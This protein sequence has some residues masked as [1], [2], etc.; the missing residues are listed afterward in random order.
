MRQSR[1]WLLC[2]KDGV[3]N[4]FR[5]YEIM[6][7]VKERQMHGVGKGNIVVRVCSSWACLPWQPQLSKKREFIKLYL[8]MQLVLSQQQLNE[9][10]P[11]PT[12][13]ARRSCAH[14]SSDSHSSPLSCRPINLQWKVLSLEWPTVLHRVE[15]WEPLRKGAKD[16]NVSYE[17]IRCVVRAARC[18]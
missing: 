8:N 2:R 1:V 5:G 13:N 10:Y 6:H 15:Q 12:K 9:I 11:P 17:S 16:Y 7:T 18:P 3:A 14:W 4:P